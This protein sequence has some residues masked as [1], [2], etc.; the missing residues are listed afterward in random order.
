MISQKNVGKLWVRLWELYQ[1][2]FNDFIN[3]FHQCSQEENLTSVPIWLSVVEPSPTLTKLFPFFNSSIFCI[4]VTTGVP[5]CSTYE[6]GNRKPKKN[7]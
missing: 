2:K 7:S 5:F 6:T 4:F 3:T 1:Y